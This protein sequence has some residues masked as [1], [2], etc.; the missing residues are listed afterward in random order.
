[1]RIW[2]YAMPLGHVWAGNVFG[3]NTGNVFLKLSGPDT[4]LTGTLRH[5][6]HDQKVII[7]YS[8]TGS[9]DGSRLQLNGRAQGETPQNLQIGDLTATA[10]LQ[11]NGHLRGEWG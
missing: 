3:T 11:P 4:G 7:V 2:E 6:D 5:H 8:V 10:T 1:M 9:F